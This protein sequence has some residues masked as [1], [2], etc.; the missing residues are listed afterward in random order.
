M[1]ES[2]LIF[3]LENDH[4]RVALVKTKPFTRYMK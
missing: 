2:M 3:P 1:K 4:P